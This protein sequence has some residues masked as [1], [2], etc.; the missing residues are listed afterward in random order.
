[1]LPLAKCICMCNY[2]IHLCRHLSIGSPF[3]VRSHFRTTPDVSANSAHS[4]NSEF[5]GEVVRCRKNKVNDLKCARRT[6]PVD[7]NMNFRQSIMAIVFFQIVRCSNLVGSELTKLK[8]WS[9]LKE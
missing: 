1:M 2:V 4:S 5:E 7:G 9:G 6:Y 3:R 8:H